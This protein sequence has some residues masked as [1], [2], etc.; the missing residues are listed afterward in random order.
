MLK[1]PPIPLEIFKTICSADNI[2]KKILESIG[3]DGLKDLSAELSSMLIK[4][5]EENVA[6]RK[7][8]KSILRE[9][10]PLCSFCRY[11][12][13]SYCRSWYNEQWCKCHAEWRGVEDDEDKQ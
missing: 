1:K 2:K 7:D 5:E 6:L 11:D 13:A 3:S 10:H 4:L 8:I 9:E 12:N